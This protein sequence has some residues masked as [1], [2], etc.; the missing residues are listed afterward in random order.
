[1]TL[2]LQDRPHRPLVAGRARPWF[3]GVLWLT[4]FGLFVVCHGCHGD[5]DA[6]L[7]AVEHREPNQPIDVGEVEAATTAFPV[8]SQ[9]RR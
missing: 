3:H 2:T 7:S 9:A 6:E 8:L 4:L 5:E 1:M